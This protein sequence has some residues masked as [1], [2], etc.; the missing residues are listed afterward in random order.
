MRQN[1]W[2]RTLAATLTAVALPWAVTACAA[3][4]GDGD[5]PG[6]N[7]QD[8]EDGEGGEDGGDE[9]EEE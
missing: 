8:G 1:T 2:R 5:N 3:E 9:G 4:E 7:Q 6:I